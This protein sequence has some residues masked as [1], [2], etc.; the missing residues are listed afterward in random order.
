MQDSKMAE[1]LVRNNK[2]P[3]LAD[4][5]RLELT[6]N[7]LPFWE[8]SIVRPDGQ[9][10]FGLVDEHGVPDGSAPLGSVM[11]SRILWTFSAAERAFPGRYREMAG[12]A[13]HE[14][15]T[16][17][18][19]RKNGGLYWMVTP[20]GAPLN[21]RKQT[22]AQAF[23][24]YALAEHYRAT[25]EPRSLELATELY[26]L[27]ERHARDSNG[28]G[29]IEARDQSWQPIADQRL[30]EKD[31]NCPK[32]MN[33]H[34]HVLEA[35]SNLLRVWRGRELV[36][37]QTM[38]M[39]ITLRRILAPSRDHLRLFFDT[40]W[41]SLSDTVS[42]GHDIEA[43][44]LLVEAATLLEDDAVL[45]GVTDAAAKLAENV[46]RNGVAS[47]G[48]LLYEAGGD[49]KITDAARHWWVQAEG[50]VG[51]YNA[52]QITRDSRFLA[53]AG[54]LWT[55]IRDKVV[56][57]RYGEWHARLDEHGLPVTDGPERYKA[58]PWKCPYHN[59]RACLE[60]MR[61][62]QE[63][64]EQPPAAEPADRHLAQSF[65]SSAAE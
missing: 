37:N 43:S 41:H 34:L 57:R 61:R 7:I 44:W 2:V 42:F 40:G 48:S 58:G 1:P 18:W 14:L 39:N 49:G 62:S 10:F 52:Y 65:K 36:D 35:Y 3:S 25:G 56:D 45:V 51:F 5:M 4:Q 13:W 27:I 19:D 28:S 22:Y 29:Y 47:D 31:L 6:G 63:I 26:H 24:L 46:L 11:V 53:A 8:R 50:V 23:G 15:T 9:G 30:S 64:A 60:I 55:F 38:L 16:K 12:K 21:P 17:F 59:A 20:S 32:S 54:K 33:T